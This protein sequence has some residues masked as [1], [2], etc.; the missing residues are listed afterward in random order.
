MCRVDKAC[1]VV[2]FCLAMGLAGGRSA[3]GQSAGGS[4]PEGSPFHKLRSISGATGHEDK[5][6]FVMDD[7]RSAFTSG[8][9]TKV[10]VYFE[11]EGPLGQHHFEGLWKSP[12]GKIV[13]V[14]DFS[15]E[16]KTNHYSGY[17][18]ML[19]SDGTPSG[20]WSLEARIDGEA[21]GFHSF[22]IT[23][24]PVATAPQPATPQP[25]SAAEMYKTAM[26][27]TVIIEKIGENGDVLA[28]KTGFWIENG[29]VLTSFGTID[30]A[31]SL[32]VRLSDGTQRETDRILGWNRWQDWA[33]VSIPRATGL[34]LKRG[35][36]EP[37]NVGDRCVF[38]EWVP[39]GAK[40]TDGSITGKNTFQKAGERMLV[41]SGATPESIGGALLNDYGEYVGL[42]SGD[43]APGSGSLRILSL[44]NAVGG[45]VDLA[46]LDT[47]G[48]AVPLSLL[49]SNLNE[50][51]ASTLSEIEKRGEFI[52][53]VVKTQLVSTASLSTYIAKDPNSAIVA[54][55]YREIFSRKDQKGS[56]YVNWWNV[57]KQK[58]TCEVRLFNLDN[59]LLVGSQPKEITLNPDKFMA[60]AWDIPVGSMVPGVY[61][62]D[63][64]VG[65][66]VAW[67]EFF[68]VTE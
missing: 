30:G 13:L 16:A 39:A 58:I 51:Q 7:A 48:L 59:R 57:K 12:T 25:L 56:L 36:K 17:W 15:Y 67:R 33:V 9:D 29:E 6:R 28:K 26:G 31:R 5:G 63:L 11:W 60:T 10:I 14:S 4:T 24:T 3:W 41:A 35:P 43:V 47:T 44:I 54:R 53:P 68:R 52:P 66:Q 64:V 42:I 18:T 21:A 61:R 45:K 32:R 19:L 23:G 46:G 49:P 38:L 27:A 20:E 1:R 62:I 37:V 40:L 50:V 22:L 55:E 2:T 8:K 34:K 65:P